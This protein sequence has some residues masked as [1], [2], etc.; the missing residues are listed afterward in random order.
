MTFTY[1]HK[2]NW[3]YKHKTHGHAYMYAYAIIVGTA[4][5]YGYDG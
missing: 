3:A 5:R 1:M 2:A 4:D